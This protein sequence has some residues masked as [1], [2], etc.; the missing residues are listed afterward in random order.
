[1]P[2]KGKAK[3]DFNNL[4]LSGI[5]GIIE[6]L[7]ILNDTTTFNI[8]NLGFKESS[9]FTVRKLNSSVI[10]AGQNILLNSAFISCDSSIL[11]I[12]RF[13]LIADSSNSL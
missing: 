4:N 9:G 11:N 3:I 7:K 6:D 12:S 13:G 10:L 2:P 8:Y 5:N 1:M